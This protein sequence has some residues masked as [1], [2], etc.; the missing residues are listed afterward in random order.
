MASPAD[1]NGE[2]HPSVS[3]PFAV[4]LP[5]TLPGQR[6]VVGVDIGGT[7]VSVVV[8][9]A[10]GVR[11]KV[12]EPTAKHGESGALALQ[13]R[14]L[15]HDSCSLAGVSV[16]E[17]GR[18]GISACGPFVLRDGL[19]EL[20][21]PNICGG[22]SKR[23]GR[24]NDWTTAPL[25]APLAAE[26]R[27]VR[28][29][30]DGIAALEAERRWGALQ[31]VD[32]CAYVTWSTGIGVG[33]CVDGRVLRGKN[34]NA[35]HAGHT[36]VSAHSDEI[37]GCGLVGD[38]ESLVSGSAVARRFP[39]QGFADAA[40]LFSALRSGD[41]AAEL[42]VDELCELMGRALFNLVVTLD[43]QRI[44]LGGSVF[45]HNSEHILPRLKNFL[46]GKL[47]VITRNVELLPAGL[48][49]AVGDF[50]ALA[51]VVGE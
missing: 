19:V 8:A 23:P 1:C 16:L 3:L 35:G 37:C 24:G 41:R 45:L 29:E 33:L 50:A 38:L 30:N 7:K 14:R 17:L 44:S 12:T 25:E 10:Q 4:S 13:V 36:F 27:G 18:M 20:A 9:D 51:L 39:N 46:D 48:G 5:V 40:V 49:A 22:L 32:H 31:G 28:V 34:G 6:P 42:I 47:P 2:Q 11:G 26:F 15:V 43:L 21:T